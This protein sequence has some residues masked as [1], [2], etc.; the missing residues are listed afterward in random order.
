MMT[1]QGAY[2]N[3]EMGG[4][5]TTV[6]VRDDL[7]PGDY[8]DPEWYNQPHGTMAARVSSDPNFGSPPRRKA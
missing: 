4:I 7:Q 1:G 5:F 8:N 2:G 3:I 6:K